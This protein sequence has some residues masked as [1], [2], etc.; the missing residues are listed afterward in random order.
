MERL[1]LKPFWNLVSKLFLSKKESIWACIRCSHILPGRGRS[2]M[3]QRSSGPI[4]F[5]I[6]GIGITVA[7]FHSVGKVEKSIVVLMILRSR[8]G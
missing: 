7:L 2:E 4:G 6:F 5:D 1:V 3:G 8:S